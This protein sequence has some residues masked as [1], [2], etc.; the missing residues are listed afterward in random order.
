[1]Q[2]IFLLVLVVGLAACHGRYK[3]G[4]ER[5]RETDERLSFQLP[6]ECKVAIHT[7]DET[8]QKDRLT[9]IARA[10]YWYILS[11]ENTNIDFPLAHEIPW[12]AHNLT[13]V[14]YYYALDPFESRYMVLLSTWFSAVTTTITPAITKAFAGFSFE[15]NQEYVAC[16]GAFQKAIQALQAPQYFGNPAEYPDFTDH[17]TNGYYLEDNAFVQRRLAGQCPFLIQKVITEGERGFKLDDLMPMLNQ[18]FFETFE[19]KYSD[20]M[21]TME[22]A[23]NHHRLFVLHLPN[24]KDIQNAPDAHGDLYTDRKLSPLTSPI[25]FFLLGDDG[26]LR[27]VA[28]QRY[29]KSS[30]EV[31]TPSSEK[32]IWSLVKGEAELAS[33]MYCQSKIHLGGVHFVSTIYCL[34][35]RRHLSTKHPL[36][37][38]FKYHCEGTVP[39]ITT[40]FGTLTTPNSLGSK[41]YGIG[42]EGLVKLAKQ[43]YDERNYEHSTF[44]FFIRGQ[45]L[46]DTRIKYY[47]FREDAITLIGEFNIFIENLLRRYYGSNSHRV[48]ADKELQSWVNELSIDGKIQP[49]GGKGK[50]IAFPSSFRWRSQLKTFLQRFMWMNIFHTSANYYTHRDFLPASPSK[51]YELNNGTQLPYLQA[52]SGKAYNVEYMRFE[53][54]LNNFRVNRIFSYWKDITNPT[55]R[56]IVRK[57]FYRLNTIVQ[58]KLETRNAE[59]KAKNQLGYQIMEPKWLTNSIHI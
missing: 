40:V 36:Y 56:R 48:R 30:S 33:D 53:G 26:L 11:D 23:I 25:S 20:E 2:R 10:R 22:E 54:M 50:V 42:S 58:K 14:N 16:Y 12:L 44:D 1:M 38:F 7:S 55:Y 37:D 8:C 49:D 46:D 35:F 32:N 24:M 51:F 31:Y 47:P 18:D 5:W 34:S 6:N 27:L 28:I 52:L 13:A 43:S 45:G 39:H 15:S 21:V 3:G 41:L 19:M 59:R 4:K 29:P 9:D 17:I 57:A